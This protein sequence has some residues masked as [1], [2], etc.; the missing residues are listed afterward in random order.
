LN[1]GKIEPRQEQIIYPELPFAVYREI[2][3]HLQQIEGIKTNLIPQK[4]SHF[5]YNQSQVC[6]LS[7]EYSGAISKKRLEEILTYY[8]QIYGTY[9]KI[10]IN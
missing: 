6:G 7:V 4:S 9:Q 3:A 1:L 10:V 5:D 2:S 8:A